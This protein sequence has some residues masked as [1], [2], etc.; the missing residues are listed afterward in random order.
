MCPAPAGVSG[1]TGAGSGGAEAGPADKA[2]KPL[3][4]K[5]NVSPETRD[6]LLKKLEAK[7]GELSRKDG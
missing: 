1:L 4:N 6:D 7:C 3:R 5:C 2:E